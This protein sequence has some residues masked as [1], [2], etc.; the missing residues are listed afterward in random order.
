[1]PLSGKAADGSWN[2]TPLTGMVRIAAATYHRRMYDAFFFDAAGQRIPAEDG[3]TG[4][5]VTFDATDEQAAI[6][7]AVNRFPGVWQ[8][9]KAASFRLRWAGNGPDNWFYRSDGPSDA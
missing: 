1:M 2:L 9:P 8:V 7:Y 3:R 6:E 4:Y 5:F